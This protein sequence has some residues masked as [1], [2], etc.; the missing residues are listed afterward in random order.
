MKLTLLRATGVVL[1]AAAT[2]AA[3]TPAVAPAAG[4]R[5]SVDT[6][7]AATT[8]QLRI[9]VQTPSVQDDQVTYVM[10]SVVPGSYAKKDYGR[11]VQDFRALDDKGKPLKVRREGANLFIIDKARRL[12]RLEYRVDDTW[13]ARMDA[14]YVFQ[15][16]GTNFDPTAAQP[17]FVLNHYGLYGYLEAPGRSY[18]MLPYEVSVQH[19]AALYGATALPAR[20]SP[21]QDVFTAD[22]YVTLADGPIL[23]ARPDTASLAV[24]GARIHVAVTSETGKVRAPQVLEIIR[25]MAEALG[26]FF[27]Q[28]PVPQYH[29]LMYFPDFQTSKVINRQTGAYGA[30]EHSYSSL[31]FMPERN[32]EAELRE[33]VQEIASHEFLH[34]LA[35]LN[36]HSREIGEFDFRSPRMSQHL[37]LYEGVT[38]YFAHLAQVQA[39]ITTEDVFRRNMRDKIEASQK[40]PSVSFTEMSRRI[41][42]KPYDAM[43]DNVY[44]KGALIGWLLDIRIQE[45]SQGRRSLRDV[46]LTLRERYG[47][48]RSFEDQQLI[49]EIVALTH[50]QVQQFFDAYVVGD[51]P[52]PLAEY[53]EKIGWHYTANESRRLKAYGQLGFRYNERAQQFEAAETN[54]EGNVFGVQNGDVIVAVNGQPVSLQTAEQLLR[55]LL[56]PAEAAVRLTLRRGTTTLDREAAP[57]EFEVEIRN[58]LEPNPSATPQQLELRRRLLGPRS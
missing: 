5:I 52:L 9:V 27:G 3:Q 18:K 16:G 11:F 40:F 54:P 42:E 7:P 15:P 25:P 30:M 56:E 21:G 49:P 14:S 6:R 4:Y 8:D 39:G 12:A 24:G 23:Y 28:M 1:L 36:I 38:E 26:R 2:A 46:L 29:F 17:N 55:P 31:Y 34:M 41:L 53:L 43:Y 37:W 19:D 22:S 58:Q 51:Q 45:L 33:M 50:P 48:T 32:T 57:R 20:R 47:P 35:P 44:Q 10:P 13:D